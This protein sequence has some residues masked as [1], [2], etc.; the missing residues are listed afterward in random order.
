MYWYCESLCLSYNAL[1]HVNILRLPSNWYSQTSLTRTRLTRVTFNTIYFQLSLQVV[2]SFT[3]IL[4]LFTQTCLT[5][6]IVN[7][8][9]K[10][11]AFEIFPT[12]STNKAS[13]PKFALSAFKEIL[14]KNLCSTF[15][16]TVH[17][18]YGVSYLIK[19]H[20]I[21]GYKISFNVH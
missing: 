10:R 17:L 19:F 7:N 5:Q 6:N 12:F 9:K 8:H 4:A 21:F 13:F 2:Q 20:D 1:I 14:N 16:H 18:F 3:V 11:S 15:D